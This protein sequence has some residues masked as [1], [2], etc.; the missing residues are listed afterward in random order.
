MGREDEIEYLDEDDQPDL[1][2]RLEQ[3]PEDNIKDGP[4]DLTHIE[5]PDDVL[6]IG[7]LE[8]PIV[9]EIKK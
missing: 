6:I 1:L 3:L 7:I 5:N 9:L 2:S 8:V 4:A